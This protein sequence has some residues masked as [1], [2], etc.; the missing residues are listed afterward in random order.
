MISL[1]AQEHSSSKETTVCVFR[2]LVHWTYRLSL[3]QH[4][5]HIQPFTY[6]KKAIIFLFMSKSFCPDSES[7]VFLHVTFF[8]I[9]YIVI[10]IDHPKV[11]LTI[12]GGSVPWLNLLLA[13]T[14]VSF[15]RFSNVSVQVFKCLFYLSGLTSIVSLLCL[16]TFGKVVILPLKRK[17]K[18][19]SLG[20]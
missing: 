5:Q 15:S 16:V 13:E 8:L 10:L 2:L 19:L 4:M 9:L 7:L 12:S 6:V 18:F 17:Q 1:F 14:Q 20:I 11:S 3:S